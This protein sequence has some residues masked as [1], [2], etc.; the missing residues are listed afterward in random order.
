MYSPKNVHVFMSVCSFTCVRVRVRVC[1]CVC[2]C[3]CV[4]V[5]ACMRVYVHLHVCV[6]VGVFFLKF[7]TC[8]PC[9]FLDYI[10]VCFSS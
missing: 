8:L 4:R 9:H 5:C 3:V 7:S 2:V 6:C 10:T 1:V